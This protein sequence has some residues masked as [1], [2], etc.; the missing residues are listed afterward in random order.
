MRKHYIGK[1]E[2]GFTLIE[3]LVVIAIIAILTA[4]LFPVFSQAREKARQTA[5][6]NNLKQC[7]MALMLYAEDNDGWTPSAYSNAMGKTWAQRLVEGKYLGDPACLVCPSC[8]PAKFSGSYSAVYGLWVYEHG[9]AQR[10]WGDDY[11]GVGGV[12]YTAKGPAWQIVLADS[13]SSSSQGSPQC[14]YIY[15]WIS[16]LRFFHLRH[17]G[18]ANAFFA[19]GHV[20]VIGTTEL[21]SM[22]VQYCVMDGAVVENW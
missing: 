17:N 10:L 7:G 5:C 1:Q 11:K 2:K 3:L 18:K 8:A 21:R 19:D 22:N 16:T 4:I 15:G 6:T 14:Y 12:P 13:V 9:W 20:A